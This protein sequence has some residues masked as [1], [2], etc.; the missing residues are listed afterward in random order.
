ME[1]NKYYLE[2][3]EGSLSKRN[4][5]ADVVT[6][7]KKV[8][9][10]AWKGTEMYRSY[11]TFGQD[12]KDHVEETESV[13]GFNGI[14]YIDY[15]ILDIDKGD[16]PDDHFIG[17]VQQ[18]ISEMFD[19]GVMEEDINLWFSGS[20]FH[21]EIKNVFGLQPSRDIHEKLKLTMNK[22]FDFAD[23]I[24]DKTRIIRCKWSLNTKTN[25]HKVW[26]PLQLLSD[27]DMDT[28]QEIS[29]SQSSYM[30]YVN[31]TQAAMNTSFFSTLFTEPTIEPYLQ[32]MVVASPTIQYTNKNT[33]TDSDVTSVVSCMQHVFNEGPMKGSRNM[34]LMRMVSA[35]KRAGVP[36]LVALNGMFTWADNTMSEEEITRTVTNVYEGSYQYG[37]DD[38]IMAA[39]CDSKCIYYKRKDYTLDIKGVDALEDALRTYVTKQLE[40]NSIKLQDIYG[41]NPYQFSPGEL[42]IFSGDTGLGKTAFIQDLIVKAKQQTLFL[43]LEMNEQLI[44][45][46]FV[47]IATNKPKEWVLEQY[48][49]NPDFSIKDKLDHVQVMTI[50]PR[51]ESIKKVVAEYEPKVLVVDTTDEVEVDFV[52]G[53][54]EK[55]NV[56]IGALKQIAQKTNIIIIAIHHLNKTSAANNV[57]NLHSLKGSSNVVQKADKVVLIKGNRNDPAREITSVKSRDEGQFKMLAAFNATNMTFKQI[58]GGNTYVEEVV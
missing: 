35:Y 12:F 36:M 57:I 14:A 31:K 8:I 17:Y 44:F 52:K 6:Y 53:E 3:V 48:K 45:R 43:S 28:I 51:I 26:I 29:S 21:I 18:C 40:Q 50:A 33:N 58:N 11:F 15:I 34:K 30:S 37:C 47:Q 38:H 13:K 23:S 25:L 20:G 19:K 42:V 27:L 56:V 4:S 9:D 54:I 41:C 16:I 22:H 2:L 5:I 39:Y 10:N 1:E 32:S 49:N 24:Y 55:Q 46:R 7:Q